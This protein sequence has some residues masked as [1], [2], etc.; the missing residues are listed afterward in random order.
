MATIFFTLFLPFYTRN[1]ITKNCRN[2][3][4]NDVAMKPGQI[5]R[6]YISVPK[7]TTWAGQWAEIFDIDH[8]SA[9]ILNSRTETI[10]NRCTLKDNCHQFYLKWQ[11][12]CFVIVA[13]SLQIIWRSKRS[14]IYSSFNFEEKYRVNVTVGYKLSAHPHSI[15]WI[16]LS[17]ILDNFKV[18][19]RCPRGW[20]VPFTN[21]FEFIAEQLYS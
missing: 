18:L 13:K 8:K 10:Q 6:Y 20:E 5:R 12:I 17:L 7:G 2:F 9:F 15:D 4:W 16:P 14:L 3:E 21:R 19:H 11:A 1:Q